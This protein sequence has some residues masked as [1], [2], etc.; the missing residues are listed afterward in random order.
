MEAVNGMVVA[1]GSEEGEMES[2]WKF[3]SSKVKSS[4]DWPYNAVHIV[5]NVYCTFKMS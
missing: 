3:Q 5:N 4:R 1:G 2:Y